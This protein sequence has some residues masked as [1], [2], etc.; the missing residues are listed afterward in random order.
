MSKYKNRQIR[1]EGFKKKAKSL[2]WLPIKFTKKNNT[3]SAWIHSI[4]LLQKLNKI[5]LP[6]R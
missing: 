3:N 4:R 6:K 5:T 2:T 1:K